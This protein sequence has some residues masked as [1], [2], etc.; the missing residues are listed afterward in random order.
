MIMTLEQAKERYGEIKNGA[1]LEESKF[2]VVVQVPDEIA[3]HLINSASGKPCVHIYAN[4]DMAPALEAVFTDIIAEK[5]EAVL[6]TFDGCLMVRCV[7]GQPN[8]LSTHCFALAVDFDAHKNQLGEK[9]QMDPRIVA[10]FKRHGF[11]WGGDFKR[12]DG[13]HFSYAWE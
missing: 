10:I 2:C 5:L 4:K 11:S 12:R 6:E 1:W 9:P 13:M 8:E 3:C 7:R